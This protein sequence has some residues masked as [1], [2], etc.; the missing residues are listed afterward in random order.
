MLLPGLLALHL[1]RDF[2]S[3]RLAPLRCFVLRHEQVCREAGNRNMEGS[4]FISK[5]E[6]IQLEKNLVRTLHSVFEDEFQGAVG[7]KRGAAIR[8]A[9]HGNQGFNVGCEWAREGSV[10]TSKA[11]R[12]GL[13][14]ELWETFFCS[15]LKFMNSYCC[16][17]HPA[18]Y[19]SPH[20]HFSW[21][22]CLTLVK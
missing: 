3:E 18:N 11:R 4:T 2:T 13:Q 9:V 21:K 22:F 6:H 20:T 15:C 16:L 19:T 12:G 1:Q 17:S 7:R 10:G 8:K 14:A 5:S